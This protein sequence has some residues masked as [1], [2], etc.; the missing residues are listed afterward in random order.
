MSFIYGR[1]PSPNTPVAEDEPIQL[2]IKQYS[3]ID[4]YPS[5]EVQ[6]MWLEPGGSMYHSA[7]LV[8]DFTQATVFP[9]SYNNPLEESN[10]KVVKCNPRTGLVLI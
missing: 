1:L 3:A 6:P 10:L 5:I 7:V 4:R 8:C 9:D 2:W